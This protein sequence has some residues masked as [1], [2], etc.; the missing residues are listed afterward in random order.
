MTAAGST[1]YIH[2]EQIRALVQAGRSNQEIARRLGVHRNTVV[3]GRRRL[4]L[5]RH[6]LSATKR[7]V[8][9]LLQ[10]TLELTWRIRTQPTSDGHLLWTGAA[11]RNGEQPFLKFRGES[12]QAARVAWRL[13]HGTEPVGLVRVTCGQPLCVRAEHLTDTATRQRHNTA[14]RYILGIGSVQDTCHRGHDP[15]QQRVDPDGYAYCNACRVEL[16]HRPVRHQRYTEGRT[17]A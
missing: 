1:R 8:T 4:G 12:H 7:R 17:A 9:H 14:L 15:K 2:D 6:D 10:P 5:S 11:A 13:H 16:K 3:N